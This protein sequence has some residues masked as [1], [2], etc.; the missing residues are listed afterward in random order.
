M[1]DALSLVDRAIGLALEADSR[2]LRALER[3]QTDRA[4]VIAQAHR[5]LACWALLR[6]V[7]G[8]PAFR[9][10]RDRLRDHIDR[11]ETDRAPSLAASLARRAQCAGRA[12]TAQALERLGQL[13]ELALDDPIGINAGVALRADS[14]AWLAL[15]ALPECSDRE[16]LWRG[17]LRWYRRGRRLASDRAGPSKG[18]WQ[19]ARSAARYSAA[20]F[21]LFSARPARVRGMVILAA[22]LDRH[23]EL[24]A[25]RGLAAEAAGSLEPSDARRVRR[26]L[27]R[28][29]RRNRA[30]VKMLAGKVY[31]DRPKRVL[32]EL[33][34]ALARPH[35]FAPVRLAGRNG[36]T[37][38]N[39]EETSCR[40]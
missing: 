12:R 27:S 20:Q 5:V 22:R 16:L 24:D 30:R 29:Q 34:A 19:R 35:A 39:F 32:A 18:D 25:L 7:I 17:C 14:D 38:Q 9:D 4:V 8:R 10:A 23:M 3:H 6:P 31:A 11:L 1:N 33:Q 15:G 37:G 21:A 40:V 36:A 26:A 28:E 13:A 2:A